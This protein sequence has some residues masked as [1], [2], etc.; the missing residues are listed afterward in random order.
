VLPTRSG[1]YPELDDPFTIAPFAT[2]APGATNKTK[3]L[4]LNANPVTVWV[5]ASGSQG[6][7]AVALVLTNYG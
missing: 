7:Y 2:T 3:Y 4:A 5:D 1:H 6:F